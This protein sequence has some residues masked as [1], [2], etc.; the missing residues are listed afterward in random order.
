MP[1]RKM[2]LKPFGVRC[3]AENA[4]IG[5]AK[6]IPVRTATGMPSTTSGE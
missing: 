4:A 6:A 3:V 5:A 1:N 2:T